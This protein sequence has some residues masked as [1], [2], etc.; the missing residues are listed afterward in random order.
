M[1]YSEEA[2]QYANRILELRREFYAQ[3]TL[4]TR[5]AISVKCN[6]FA[7]LEAY[8]RELN[9]RKLRASLQK[10]EDEIASI[11]DELAA[12]SQE[13]RSLLAKNGFSQKDLED[14]HGCSKC[15]DTGILPDGSLC[16]CKAELMRKYEREKL[17]KQS[18]LASS[19]FDT[20][21]LDRYS[22][23]VDPL[24]G[25]SPFEA[26]SDNLKRCKE[27]A[28]SFPTSDNLL[29][30][31]GTGLGKTHLALSIAG[32]VLAK[33][34]E[35]LYCSCSNILRIIEE[36][37]SV[38][39]YSDTLNSLKRCDLLILDDLGSEFINSYSN[40]LLYDILNT[41]LSE[42]KATVVTTNL[43]EQNKMNLRYGAKITSRLLG[44]FEIRACIGS[45]L[46]T[47]DLI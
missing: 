37:R 30:M 12:L 21:S 2:R 4:A 25:I 28:F 44:S 6:G 35:V 41:R 20:F 42:K 5:E 29:L 14:L 3:K 24:F 18:P 16:S 47:S 40:A 36:E 1:A 26:M 22:K 33:G 32:V 43:E 31:G 45:D 38:M 13:I 27:Y 9:L 17:E 23:E 11:R 8:R 15:A 46:R 10:N 7:E 39:R 34:Y 19:S